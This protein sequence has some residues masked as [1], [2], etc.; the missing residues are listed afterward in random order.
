MKTMPKQLQR[1]FTL[2]ELMIVVAIIGILAAIAIPQYSDYTSRT[3]ATGS[4]AELNSLIT[5]MSSCFQENNGTWTQVGGTDCFTSNQ[6]GIPVVAT[7]KFIPFVP[8]VAAGSVTMTSAAT[9]TAGVQLT[10]VL[11][12]STISNQ[13]NMKWQFNGGNSICSAQRGLKSGQ[14][15]CP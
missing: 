4:R 8:T 10:G 6:N 13:A 14:G 11:T 9:T 1:G 7:S 2:I 5:S 12:P 3:R 15:G